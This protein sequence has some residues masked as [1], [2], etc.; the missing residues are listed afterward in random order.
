MLFKIHKIDLKFLWEMSKIEIGVLTNQPIPLHDFNFTSYYVKSCTGKINKAANNMI[1]I[2]SC[3]GDNRTARKKPEWV[4]DS[5]TGKAIRTN[6]FHRF[7]WDHICPNAEDYKTVLLN[8][9]KET[10]ITKVAGIHLDCIGFPDHDYCTCERCTKAQEVSHLKWTDWRSKVVTNFVAEASKIVKEN[11]KSFS[12]TLLPDPCFGK[13]RYGEDFHSLAEYVDFF[14]VPIYDLVY[15][16]TYWLET[17]AYDFS[18]QL[19]KPLYIE[20][21]AADPG[22]K[23]KTLLSAMVAVSNYVDGIILATHDSTIAKQ[24]KENLTENLEF[25]DLLERKHQAPRLRQKI[26]SWKN[27]KTNQKMKS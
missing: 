16:T 3:F 7:L 17:L 26:Q 6:R 25:T 13:E 12:V 18:K 8:L 21:Y 20:L 15:S 9:I 14:I 19:K 22:P 5:K 1:N 4:A 2:I 11:H 27:K 23:L 24:I 10:S